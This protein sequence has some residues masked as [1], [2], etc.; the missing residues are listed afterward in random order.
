[1]RRPA[2]WFTLLGPFEHLPTANAMTNSTLQPVF[3]ILSQ[4]GCNTY[5]VGCPKTRDAMLID[6]KVGGEESYKHMLA[7]YKLNLRA[8]VDTHT[9]AD[10]LSA[11]T[12][13]A[14]PNVKLYMSAR[15]TVERIKVSVQAGDTVRVGE[16]AFEVREVPGHTDD[17]IALIGHGCAF[18]GD[19]LFIGGLARADFRGSKP[20]LLFDSVQQELMSLPPETLVFPG[21][22]YNGFLFSTIGF[23]AQHNEALQYDSGSEYAAQL[24]AREGAGNTPA[25]DEMLTLNVEANPTLPDTPGVAAACGSASGGGRVEIQE[26]AAA[27]AGPANSALGSPADWIDVRDPHECNAAHIPGTTSIPLSE[28]GFHL[29]ALRSDKPL[30][31]SCRSGVRSMTAARTLQRL[32]VVAHPIN[33]GGGILG[34]Q[35]QGLPVEA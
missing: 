27:D 14:G 24:G 21:H 5:M 33:V 10:H 7:A 1:M 12:R 16:L 25:V 22:G 20:A 26:I 17:S 11:S 18:T 4:D 9:H 15:T 28:L 6:P 29:A 8:I 13:L 34:W 30:Y 35:A 2:R 19:S 32:G 31:I 23:E 3:K